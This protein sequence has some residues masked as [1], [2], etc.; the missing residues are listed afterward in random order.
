MCVILASAPFGSV[1][2]LATGRFWYYEG[3]NKKL[4]VIGG[5][6]LALLAITAAVLLLNG[7]KKANDNPT[8][9]TAKPRENKELDAEKKANIETMLE[10]GIYA[11]T[12]QQI[13]YPESTKDGWTEFVNLLGPSDLYS[14]VDPFTSQYYTYVTKQQTPDY[15][16]IQYAPGFTCDSK[17]LNFAAGNLRYIAVRSKFSTGVKC[18]SSIQIQKEDSSQQ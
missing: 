10:K 13:A 5:V 4:L 16:E 9:Q 18:I 7:D 12:Q 15:S 2:S 8:S 1:H 17:G 3:M 11:A 6:V 14:A